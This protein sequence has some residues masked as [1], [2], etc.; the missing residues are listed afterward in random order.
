[1]DQLV[2][3]EERLD[4]KSVE[5]EK[6]KAH[7]KDELEKEKKKLEKTNAKFQNS[8][9]LVENLLKQKKQLTAKIDEGKYMLYV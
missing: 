9:E 6:V 1:M 5:C 3:L 4:T 7:S 8:M 2:Q